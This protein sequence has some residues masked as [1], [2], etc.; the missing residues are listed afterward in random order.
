MPKNF[1]KKGVS[2][3]EAIIVCF[4]TAILTLSAVEIISHAFGSQVAIN[5]NVRT[6][7]YKNNISERISSKIKEGSKPYYSA[8]SLS[9]SINEYNYSVQPEVNSLAVLI[10]KFN[11]DGSIVQ[12]STGVTTFKGVAFSIIPKNIVEPNA[13]ETD[14][15]VI[16]ETTAEFDLASSLSDPVV[17]NESLP[18]DWGDGE[19]YVLAENLKPAYF[20]VLGGEAFDV[21]GDQVNF[22]F[23]P[24]SGN[25]Y[26]PSNIGSLTIDDGQYITRCQ[27]RNFR[28]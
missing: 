1:A 5:K 21:E 6:K 9:I 19:S 2:L 27:F 17:I 16:V 24:V 12:P 8:L 3:P 20:T 26:F 14:T 10:P 23:I 18:T 22:A 7:Q 11:T 4:M 15:Y 25:I 13:S 28:I